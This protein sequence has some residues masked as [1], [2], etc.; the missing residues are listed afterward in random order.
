M[1]KTRMRPRFYSPVV[2]ALVFALFFLGCPTDDDTERTDPAFLV[3]TW[4]SA[5]GSALFTISAGSAGTSDYLTFVC[6]LSDVFE[7]NPGFVRGRMIVVHNRGPNDFRLDGMVTGN[8]DNPA[9]LDFPDSTYLPGNTMLSGALGTFNGILVSLRPDG[10]RFIFSTAT[11][12]ANDFFG[13]AYYR[14]EEGD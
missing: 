2:L 3:G 10:E 6:N 11:H 12:L 7:G 1:K 13:G 14:V 9:D 8:P 4:E 5:D